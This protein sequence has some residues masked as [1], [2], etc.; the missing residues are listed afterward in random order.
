MTVDICVEEKRLTSKHHH[1]IL[2]TFQNTKKCNSFAK[3]ILLNNVFVNE[4][5]E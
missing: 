4:I 1:D 2:V 5:I 3:M